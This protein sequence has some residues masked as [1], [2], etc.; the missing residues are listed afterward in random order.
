VRGQLFHT[1]E[2]RPKIMGMCMLDYYGQRSHGKTKDSELNGGWRLV[3]NCSQT[4]EVVQNMKRAMHYQ[5]IN[6]T[7]LIRVLTNSIWPIA[8]EHH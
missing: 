8:G 1:H 3:G 2:T 5:T 7:P 6:S 4:S